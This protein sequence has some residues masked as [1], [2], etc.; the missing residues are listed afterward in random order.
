MR[1][2]WESLPRL[3]KARYCHSSCTIGKILYVLGGR[4]D[5]GEATNTIE[6]LVNIDGPPR[7][8]VLIWKL[9]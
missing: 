6:K 7:V 2:T 4:D 1:E 5:S 3:N 9:I 8:G